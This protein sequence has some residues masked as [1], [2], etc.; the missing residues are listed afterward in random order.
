MNTDTGALYTTD[1]AI[2]AAQARG[3]I[4][5]FLGPEAARI[6]K[7]GQGEQRRRER[8][9]SRK[10]ARKQQRASRRVNRR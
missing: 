4:L 8:K 6:V 5:A 1:E 9:A 10:A 2:A 7:L 3:E